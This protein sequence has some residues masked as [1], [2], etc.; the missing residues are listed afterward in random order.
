MK[1]LLHKAR[2]IQKKQNSNFSYPILRRG[3]T[4][5]DIKKS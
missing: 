3:Y 1:E 4:R 5:F 2:K